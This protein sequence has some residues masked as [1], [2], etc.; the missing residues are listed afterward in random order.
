MEIVF[1][2]LKLIM[3]DKNLEEIKKY[4]DRLRKFLEEGGDW[5]KKN[6]LKV[7]EG[8]YLVMIREFKKGAK[9]F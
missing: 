2:M 7:Y 1:A 4:I 5:E 9:L 8:L 3:V 6:K